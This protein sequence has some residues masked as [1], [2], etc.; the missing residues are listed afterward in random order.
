MPWDQG[1]DFGGS[2]AGS[3]VS[4]QAFAAAAGAAVA[5][6]GMQHE[7]SS[8]AN[9]LIFSKVRNNRHT[10]VEVGRLYSILTTRSLRMHLI[11]P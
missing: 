7:A 11:S 5:V 9:H 8:G 3:L 2:E 1:S 6:A 4:Q 10:D